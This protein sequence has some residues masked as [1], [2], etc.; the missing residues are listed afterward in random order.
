VII[1]L[2]TEE[3][4]A[5]SHHQPSDLERYPLRARKP[6][7]NQLRKNDVQ[8]LDYA[9]GFCFAAQRAFINTDNFFLA[10]ALIGGRSLDFLGAD[11]PFHVAHR[12]FIAT[13]I[14]LRAAALMCRP[15]RPGVDAALAGRPRR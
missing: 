8:T 11:F 12:C 10:A 5:V 9:F 7:V 3:G 6:R 1:S 13:E 14:R 15:A 2:L 4:E